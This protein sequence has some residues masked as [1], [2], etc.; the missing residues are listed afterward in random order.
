MKRSHFLQ[1][2]FGLLGASMVLPSLVTKAQ[3]G[4]ETAPF[5]LPALAY[6]FDALEPHIDKLTMEIHHD[7]HHKA[8]VDNLNKAVM[9]TA[10]ATLSLEAMM[11][12]ISQLPTA[13]RNNGGGHWNHS[14]F[15]KLIGPAT[16]SKPSADLL[17]QIQKDLG[18]MDTLKSE[19]AKSATG[20]FGSGWA[21]LIW[22][23]GKL[24]ISS[25]PNQDNPLMDVA[26]VK[27]TPIL[28]LDVWEHA[29]YLK[30]QNKRADYINA[31]WNVVNWDFV[32]QQFSSIKK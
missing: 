12:Q 3:N 2:T 22:K 1:K 20:R 32:S 6:S 10:A 23:E 16:G 24:V 31:F 25:T 21:W 19:F 4:L 5:T 13:V 30:Y 7:R 17:A 26:E 15:W 9:G 28:A 11:G 18:G 27:G 8:Y 14:F 29:Y